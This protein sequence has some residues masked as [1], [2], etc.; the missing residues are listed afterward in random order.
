[1]VVWLNISGVV[2]GFTRYISLGSIGAM[3]A[4]PVVYYASHGAETFHQKL[5]VFLFFVALAGIVVWRHRE[6]IL[7]LLRGNERKL[8]APD[9][10]L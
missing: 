4:I 9:Q 6:N 2:V 10:Q 3:I 7:R 1:M 5:A 8:G